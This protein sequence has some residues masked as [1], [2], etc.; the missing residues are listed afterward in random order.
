M[1]AGARPWLLAACVALAGPAAGA[2]S[3]EGAAAMLERAA[4]FYAAPASKEPVLWRLAWLGTSD[5]AAV[6]QAR[7]PGQ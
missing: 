6:D 2:G 4:R 7:R 1:T 5:L 3:S